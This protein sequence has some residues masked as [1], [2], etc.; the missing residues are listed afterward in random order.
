MNNLTALADEELVRLYVK[1][2]NDAFDTLLKRYE[3]R[4]F[5]YIFYAVKDQDLANDLFQDVFVRVISTLNSGKY[6]ENGKFGSW[7][8]RITHNVVIDNFR[9][10]SQI[11]GPSKDD[12]KVNILNEISLVSYDNKESDMVSGQL[13]KDIK[14]LID[15]LPLPQ[16]EA[17]VMRFFYDMSFK[18]IAEATGVSIST[19]LGRVRYGL[20]TLRRLARD[21]KVHFAS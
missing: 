12:E 1:G 8:I 5:S 15:F 6:S 17:I 19:A 14:A 10:S 9:Q 20:S 7:I 21:K 13:L 4:V 2:N 18:E 11:T 16:K 3:S